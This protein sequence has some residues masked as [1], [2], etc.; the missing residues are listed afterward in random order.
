MDINAEINI[1][2][3]NLAYI[4]FF[5][6]IF[7]LWGSFSSQFLYYHQFLLSCFFF[8]TER[9]LCTRS[10][11]RCWR[12]HW[13]QSKCLS[14]LEKI[15]RVKTVRPREAFPCSFVPTHYKPY[16][17]LEAVH[18][19]IEKTFEFHTLKEFIFQEKWTINPNKKI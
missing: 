6:L 10:T 4:T 12:D 9:V 11:S 14:F 2:L 8:L 3:H 17:I 19:A 5:I 7:C 13:E 1:Q 18:I 16:I 15:S